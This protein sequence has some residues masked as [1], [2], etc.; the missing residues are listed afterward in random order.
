MP[1]VAAEITAPKAEDSPV[2]AQSTGKTALQYAILL[3]FYLTAVFT[4]PNLLIVCSLMI[5]LVLFL[6]KLFYRLELTKLPER[7]DSKI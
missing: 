3:G 5:G 6:A 7:V 1:K 2:V 4:G